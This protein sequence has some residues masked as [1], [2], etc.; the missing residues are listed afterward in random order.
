MCSF[1]HNFP[2]ALYKHRS[3]SITPSPPSSHPTSSPKP[4]NLLLL[5]WLPSTQTSWL[6]PI[7]ERTIPFAIGPT[8]TDDMSR[9]MQLPY[10]KF[11]LYYT[12]VSLS[13]LWTSTLLLTA[14]CVQS[15]LI[16]IFVKLWKMYR[17]GGP[18][19][20]MHMTTRIST[21]PSFSARTSIGPLQRRAIASQMFCLCID[22]RIQG[23][24]TSPRSKQRNKNDTAS[25][26]NHFITMLSV[27]AAHGVG[28]IRWQ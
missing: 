23:M 8:E 3:S 20:S 13:A 26:Y 14:R 1:M 21:C 7:K 12:E 22:K 27:T 4:T 24:L 25:A 10:H 2:T 17:T 9:T 5:S 11:A 18:C 6:L 15:H 16:D 28:N 19:T